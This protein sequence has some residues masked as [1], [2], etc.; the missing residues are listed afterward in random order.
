MTRGDNRRYCLSWSFILPPS[1]LDFSHNTSRTRNSLCNACRVPKISEARST[2][3]DFS[4]MTDDAELQARIAKIAGKINEH[5]QQQSPASNIQQ[6][7]HH[8]SGPISERDRGRWTPYERAGRRIPHQNR[9]LVLAGNQKTGVEN[10]SGSH[11]TDASGANT[12]RSDNFVSA[13]RPGMNQLM[14]QGTYEREQQQRLE[15]SEQQRVA[16]RRKIN[17]AEQSRLLHHMQLTEATM[18]RE[19]LVEGI[20]FQVRDDG[21][22]LIRIPGTRDMACAFPESCHRLNVTD[23]NSRKETP[24]KTKIAD[25][26]FHRTKHGNLVRATAVKGLNKQQPQCE[27]FTKHGTNKS[28]SIRDRRTN[29]RTSRFGKTS[30]SVLTPGVGTCPFGPSCKFTHDPYKVAVCKDQ[31]RT[32]ACVAGDMCDMSHE[33]TYHRVAACT[34]FLR[35]NCTNKSCRYPHVHVSPSAPVCASFA[36]LGFCSKGTNCAKRHVTECP[37]YTNTGRC[38]QD[39]CQLPHID[40]ASTLRKAAAKQ[41]KLDSEDDSDVSSNEEQYVDLADGDDIDSDEAEEMMI[42]AGADGSLSQQQDFVPLV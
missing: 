3:L 18:T 35:G 13:R 12:N 34:H 26:D 31:L 36:R 16:K 32:G 6:R 38:P 42:G 2:R 37:A 27:H 22:K 19:L 28:P 33:L 8:F 41:S 7:P 1:L 21:S 5:R 17:D 24:R 25:V 29:K 30:L 39:H 40:R 20:R 10:P 15:R 23:S 9:T 14:N 4:S 11:G